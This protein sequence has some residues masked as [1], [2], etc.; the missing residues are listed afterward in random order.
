MIALIVIG[1]FV[2]V[3][4]AMSDDSMIRRYGWPPDGEANVPSTEGVQN[5]G[6]AKSSMF[7]DGIQLWAQDGDLAGA[8][9]YFKAPQYVQG[10]R[11]ALKYDAEPEGLVKVYVGPKDEDCNN[12]GSS[13]TVSTDRNQYEFVKKDA[14]NY[15][16]S[17][18]WIKIEISVAQGAIDVSYIEVEWLRYQ[19]RVEI[20]YRE[21]E[22][23]PEPLY[24]Y[25]YYYDRVPIYY[26]ETPYRVIVYDNWWDTSYY[27]TWYPTVVVKYRPVYYVFNPIYAHEYSNRWRCRPVVKDYS[28]DSGRRAPQRTRSVENARTKFDRRDDKNV[29]KVGVSA[30]TQR[31]QAKLDKVKDNNKLSQERNDKALGSARKFKKGTLDITETRKDSGSPT[32]AN[33]SEQ[34]VKKDGIFTKT[35]RSTGRV[36]KQAGGAAADNIRRTF[37]VSYDSG[38]SGRSNPIPEY[39]PVANNADGKHFSN[40]RGEGRGSTPPPST[41]KVQKAS[42]LQQQEMRIENSRKESSSTKE[43]SPPPKKDDDEQKKHK[44]GRT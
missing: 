20:I 16:D 33:S 42:A 43:S 39:K 36:A 35:W 38:G 2:V 13:V 4:Q 17:D 29:A 9:Y 15:I 25:H 32:S 7:Q 1:F 37:N 5:S 26:Y 28:H 14:A 11:V 34:Q 44:R 31:S 10:I 19:P 27:N 21:R 41:E 12:S 40:G 8:D 3:T 23:P 18:N 30:D 24:I 6:V 22:A